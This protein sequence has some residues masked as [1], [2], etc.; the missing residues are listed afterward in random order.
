MANVD[1]PNGFRFVKSSTGAV[2]PVIRT[3]GVADS[4]DIWRG[5]AIALSS[6]LATE[7]ASGDTILGVAIGFGKIDPT[8]GSVSTMMDPDERTIQYYDDSNSTHT[9]Y[10]VFYIPAEG[11]IFEVQTATALT[12]AVGATADLLPTNG[13][14]T[15]GISAHEIT[16]SSNAD[17]EVVQIPDLPDNDNTLV[18]G[19]YWVQFA[20]TQFGQ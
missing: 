9:D 8:T 16:T 7:A 1:R 10:V 18:N 2:V 6:G 4:A 11:N 3:V 14:T 12:I 20:T 5:D 15:T 17:V 19:R 13:S